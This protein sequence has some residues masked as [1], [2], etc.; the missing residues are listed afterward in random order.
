VTSALDPAL[1]PTPKASSCSRTSH[2]YYPNSASSVSGRSMFIALF[3]CLSHSPVVDTLPASSCILLLPTEPSVLPCTKTV[4]DGYSY[5]LILFER[6][7]G[8]IEYQCWVVVLNFSVI[9]FCRFLIRLSR[10]SSICAM[11]S[12]SPS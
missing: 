7:T 9:L 4:S 10:S 12:L 3:T 11:Q 5:M 2:F 6:S 1:Q 8:A